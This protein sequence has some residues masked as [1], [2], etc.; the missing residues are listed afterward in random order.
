M[1]YYNKFDTLKQFYSIMIDETQ[2]KIE[3]GEKIYHLINVEMMQEYIDSDISDVIIHRS[4]SSNLKIH[5][6][7]NPE[8]FESVTNAKTIQECN[9]DYFLE[10]V[11]KFSDQKLKNNPYISKIDIDQNN[12]R[13]RYENYIY[14]G[15]I[16]RSI[17]VESLKE[18]FKYSIPVIRNTKTFSIPKIKEIITKDIYYSGSRSG[19][20]KSCPSWNK[21]IQ[22][23]S[24]YLKTYYFLNILALFGTNKICVQNMLVD[25]ENL[26]IASEL[27]DCFNENMITNISGRKTG[28]YGTV[29]P[30]E[31]ISKVLMDMRDLDSSVSTENRKKRLYDFFES[32]VPFYNFKDFTVFIDENINKHENPED[33]PSDRL[34]P[35]AKYIAME[36]IGIDTDYFQTININGYFAYRS[37]MSISFTP[38][39]IRQNEYHHQSNIISFASVKKDM[40][41]QVN[42]IEYDIFKTYEIGS[43]F[44]CNSGFQIIESKNRSKLSFPSKKTLADIAIYNIERLSGYKTN[45]R[46]YYTDYSA[47]E[48]YL[49]YV[50]YII[51]KIIDGIF[52]GDILIEDI[53]TMFNVGF[54][55]E[56]NL[57]INAIKTFLNTLIINNSDPKQEILD[58]ILKSGDFKISMKIIFGLI[59]IDYLRYYSYVLY[60]KNRPYEF[61]YRDGVPHIIENLDKI[62]DIQ[63]KMISELNSF[64]IDSLGF[65][66]LDLYKEVKPNG[67]IVSEASFINRKAFSPTEKVT[68][69]KL[70]NTNTFLNVDHLFNIFNLMIPHIFKTIDLDKYLSKY[71][72]EFDKL[73]NIRQ[74]NQFHRLFEYL[75][76]IKLVGLRTILSYNVSGSSLLSKT[77]TLPHIEKFH[78]RRTIKCA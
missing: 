77:P 76:G 78:K 62:D 28:I 68:F 51:D 40:R 8:Y 34:I 70:R 65:S 39:I 18:M 21:F 61:E 17:S 30:I 33:S 44:V 53:E 26:K 11:K 38:N 22:D 37:R 63:S 16:H 9:S 15:S 20:I 54:G 27:V 31:H 69:D 64:V 60:P 14:Y 73:K 13:N 45:R 29:V 42:E 67:Q 3:A 66:I 47:Y 50:Q 56:N 6:P 4:I 10:E 2:K 57:K 46:E 48:N 41:Y 59:I 49:G 25:E 23:F 5:I 58:K 12:S 32:M 7:L 19:G 36:N 43:F 52:I 35:F 71:M 24:S 74:P 75:E 1:R 55:S 72:E